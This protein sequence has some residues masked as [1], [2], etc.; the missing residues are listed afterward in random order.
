MNKPVHKLSEILSI[1]NRKLSIFTIVQLVA[2]SLQKEG[3]IL[4]KSCKTEEE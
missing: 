3:I 4:N 1:E 2:Q